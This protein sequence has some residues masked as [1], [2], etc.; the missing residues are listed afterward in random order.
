MPPEPEKH[1]QLIICFL[2]A[3]LRCFIL[4]LLLHSLGERTL[5]RI[6]S[7]G[8]GGSMRTPSGGAP[9]ATG[10][11]KAQ[12]INNLLSFRRFALFYH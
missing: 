3:A 8:L 2:F 4:N 7:L 11:R 6:L 12:T 1:R 9:S 5:Q 10:A